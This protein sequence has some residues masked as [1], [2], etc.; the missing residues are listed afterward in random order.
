MGIDGKSTLSIED[1]IMLKGELRVRLSIPRQAAECR[2][3]WLVMA[4]SLVMIV[5]I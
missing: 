4:G 3:V 1:R 5:C 2:A